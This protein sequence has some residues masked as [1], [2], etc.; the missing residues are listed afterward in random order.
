[1]WTVIL[2]RSDYLEDIAINGRIEM[3]IERRAVGCVDCMCLALSRD[4][5]LDVLNTLVKPRM[6]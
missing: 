5:R 1:M 3:H 2:N 4:Q 6:P